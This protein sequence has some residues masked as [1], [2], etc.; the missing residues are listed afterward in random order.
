M[1]AGYQPYDYN[2]G[3]KLTNEDN[4]IG[5]IVNKGAYTHDFKTGPV[6]HWVALYKNTDNTYIEYDSIGKK[7]QKILLLMNIKILEIIFIF[8]Y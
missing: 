2:Q 3:D 1:I 4:T 8:K 5:F 7:K 6:G